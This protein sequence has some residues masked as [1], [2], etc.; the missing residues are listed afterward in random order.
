MRL[1][2]Y[3]FLLSLFYISAK[4]SEFID[5]AIVVNTVSHDLLLSVPDDYDPGKAYPLIIGIHYC[6]GTASQFRDAMESLTDSLNV[7]IACPGY[8]SKRVPDSDTN[9][10]GILVDTVA[11]AYNIDRAE[12]YLTAMSC[13]SDF[14]LQQGLK[15]VYPFKGIFPYAPWTDSSSPTLYNFSSDMATVISIGTSDSKIGTVLNIYDSLKTHQADV[16][17]ILI[18]NVTHTLNFDEF[19]E[20]MISSMKYLNDSNKI[21]ISTIA[22]D[23]MMSNESKEFTF[24]A[25]HESGDDISLRVVC[26]RPAFLPS[27]EVKPTGKADEYKF[28]VTPNN[29][30]GKAWL[31]VEAYETNG[32]AIEQST[33][34]IVVNEVV[35]DLHT[36]QTQLNQ[37]YPNPVK[38]V[39]NLS[40]IGLNA[41][42]EILDLSGKLLIHTQAYSENLCLPINLNRGMYLL[43]IES[44]DMNKVQRIVVE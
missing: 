11:S 31:V 33:F 23:E 43:K 41:K 20:T 8:F 2:L 10:F 19:P 17:L 37:V 13:N 35:S 27:M 1:K 40:N 18:P 21:S 14:S 36:N 9:M 6:G 38:E 39:L 26:S 16:N 34:K 5:T 42:I 28:S 3:I 7:I 30:Y 24:T 25:S 12:V 32:T 15:E 29:S 4:A 22:N 44:D